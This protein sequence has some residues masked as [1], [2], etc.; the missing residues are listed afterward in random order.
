MWILGAHTASDYFLQP[1]DAAKKKSIDLK[2]FL[3]HIL[4]YTVAMSILVGTPLI[5]I[6]GWTEASVMAVL[7]WLLIT[8][9][10]HL[11]VDIFTKHVYMHYFLL[12]QNKNLINAIGVD[13]YAHQVFL[14]L[15]FMFVFLL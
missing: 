7:L 11:L 6:L 8:G 12:R 13:Q 15:A 3:Q 4:I 10:A 14:I 5:I 1:K 2:V 9:C